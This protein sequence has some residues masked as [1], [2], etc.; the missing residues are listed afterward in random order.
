MINIKI[1]DKKG[2]ELYDG[3]TIRYVDISNTYEYINAFPGKVKDSIEV[4]FKQYVIDA[5]CEFDKEN[6]FYIPNKEYTKEF[7]LEAY[8]LHKDCIQEDYIEYCL[9]PICESLGVPF[10]SEKDV[11]YRINGFEIIGE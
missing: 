6:L 5:Q 3:D 10:I 9:K 4:L 7:L 8:D 11:F 2:K 1:L